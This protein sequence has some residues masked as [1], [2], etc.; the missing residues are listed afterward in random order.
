MQNQAV[1]GGFE[2]SAEEMRAVGFKQNDVLSFEESADGRSVVVRRERVCDCPK[3]EGKD[4]DEEIT[5]YDF[6][7]GLSPQQQEAAMVHLSVKWAERK[8]GAIKGET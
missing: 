7:N 6:L 3:A 2:I 1:K 5:L 4:V 8:G